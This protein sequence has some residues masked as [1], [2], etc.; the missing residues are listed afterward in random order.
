VRFALAP[1]AVLLLGCG[2]EP[3]TGSPFAKVRTDGSHYAQFDPLEAIVTNVGTHRLAL[4]GCAHIER[5]GGAGWSSAGG[6][7]IGTCTRTII[8]PGEVFV[9]LTSSIGGVPEG[10]AR[11]TFGTIQILDSFVSGQPTPTIPGHSNIFTVTTGTP[12]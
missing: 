10:K 5:E 8:P 12:Y 11:I 7:Y 6:P 4:T 1:V 2:T 3:S 9:A